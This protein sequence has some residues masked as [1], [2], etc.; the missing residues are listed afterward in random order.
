MSKHSIIAALFM[1]VIALINV[2][3]YNDFNEA[4]ESEAEDVVTNITTEELSRILSA[5]G[6]I[7]VDEDIRVRGNVSAHDESGNF[8]KSFLIESGGY[9]VEILE[10]L[11]DSFVRHG[12]GY[13]MVIQLNGLRLTRSYGIVQIGVAASEGSYYDVDYMGHELLVDQHITNTGY[14]SLIEPREFTLSE[15]AADPELATSLCGSLIR[16]TDVRYYSTDEDDDGLWSGERCFIGGSDPLID[17]E[18]EAAIWSYVSDYADFSELSIPT[19]QGSITG[20]LM[21]DDIEGGEGWE[22][23]IKPRDLDDL[24]FQ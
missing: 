10:G 5:D 15:L 6:Y 24:I 4:E 21:G 2:C 18:A 13:E 9:G 8:Y 12:L 14:V 19:S 20:I 17:G 23:V 16:V 22:M 7:D 11:T 1:S 3:C